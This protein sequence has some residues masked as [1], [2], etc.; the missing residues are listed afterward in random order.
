MNMTMIILQVLRQQLPPPALPP[1]VPLPPTLV[2]AAKNLLNAVLP[3]F[4]VVFGQELLMV[5]DT[6]H[7]SNR[8]LSL[9]REDFSVQQGSTSVV[10]INDDDDSCAGCDGDDTPSRSFY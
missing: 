3:A 2:K 7:L 9:S 5:S 1:P 4:S 8:C 10:V 6:Q